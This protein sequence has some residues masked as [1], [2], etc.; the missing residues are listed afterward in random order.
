MID[1]YQYNTFNSNLP[2][3]S[4]NSEETSKDLHSN[5]LESYDSVKENDRNHL[6]DGVSKLPIASCPVL[7]TSPDS[8]K[9]DC[10]LSSELQSL[11]TSEICDVDST[12][13]DYSDT[14]LYKCLQEYEERDDILSVNHGN[15]SADIITPYSD[16]SDELI[17][18]KPLI[19]DDS[20][21]E[22]KDTLSSETSN[23]LSIND[24]LQENIKE[25][26]LLTKEEKAI[27]EETLGDLSNLDASFEECDTDDEQ[28]ERELEKILDIAEESEIAIDKS[29]K[30]LEEHDDNDIP[31]LP[32]IPINPDLN[33]ELE[34]QH[35][36]SI[37]IIKQEIKDKSL[38]TVS[39]NECVIEDKELLLESHNERI[40]SSEKEPTESLCSIEST[41]TIL[42]KDD[43]QVSNNTVT[44]SLDS[45]S[46][47]S[48][49]SEVVGDNEENFEETRIQ[50]PSTLDLNG[51][52][53]CKTE[54][55]S[56]LSTGIIQKL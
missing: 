20:V 35:D 34:T 7:I 27:L 26:S 6:S 21:S 18:E 36:E 54:L 15:S 19:C 32:V 29:Q 37:L 22:T 28:L 16:F 39:T 47:C 55:P 24:E 46:T 13:A 44:D 52:T 49:P 38:A 2:P 4:Y 11:N 33:L 51:I 5:L 30:H 43:N 23:D 53:N 31:N 50:R 9:D 42:L 12:N 56:V 41:E 3:D 40:Y 25:H 10:T 14:E 8:S 45:Q 1:E 17:A 48:L